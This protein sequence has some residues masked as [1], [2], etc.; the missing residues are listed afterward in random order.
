LRS[1]GMKAAS[2]WMPSRAPTSLIVMRS[3]GM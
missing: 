2:V 3:D 1:V